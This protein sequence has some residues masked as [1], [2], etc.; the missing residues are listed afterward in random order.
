MPEGQGGVCAALCNAWQLR[1]IAGK[2]ADDAAGLKKE[3][4]ISVNKQRKWVDAFAQTK[5]TDL[6]V[7]YNS[8]SH[9]TRMTFTD[10][11]TGQFVDPRSSAIDTLTDGYYILGINF[12]SE[13]HI[14]AYY[15]SGNACCI[16]DPN[17]GMFGA[18]GA[19]EIKSLV[20]LIWAKYREYGLPIGSWQIWSI[21]KAESARERMLKSLQG[22]K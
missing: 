9:V 6:T 14:V 15:K 7:N 5:S 11:T 4:D 13:A 8:I 22:V 16:Y 21:S 19:D 10:A 2:A 3:F 20:T 12:Q 1:L 18:A 17:L